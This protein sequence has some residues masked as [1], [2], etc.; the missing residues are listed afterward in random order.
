MPH[1]Y[2][3]A[4]KRGKW[5]KSTLVGRKKEGKEVRGMSIRSQKKTGRRAKR[6]QKRVRGTLVGSERRKREKI[7]EKE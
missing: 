4:K 3:L 7:K 5:V 1:D 2:F 6:G